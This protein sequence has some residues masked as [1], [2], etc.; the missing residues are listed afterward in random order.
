MNG[1][2]K[3][4]NNKG[5]GKI[6]PSRVRKSKKIRMPVVDTDAYSTEMLRI[7]GLMLCQN[8]GNPC[9]LDLVICPTCG[10]EYK[11]D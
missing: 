3:N 10:F 5:K 1:K 4:K 7:Q 2:N 9:P 8:C 6:D 11:G